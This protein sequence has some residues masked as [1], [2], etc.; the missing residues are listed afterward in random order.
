MSLPATDLATEFSRRLREIE[1]E[2][3]ELAA[4]IHAATYRLLEL[5]REFDEREGWG[6]PGMKSCAHWLNWKVGISLG[7]AREKVRVAH[8]LKDLPQIS[9][10]FRRGTVSFSKVRAMTRVATPENEGYL[11]QIADHGTASHVEKLVRQFRRVKR[12][13]AMEQE[14]ARH[15]LRELSWYVDD[16]GSYVF[17]ARLTPEQGER[18]AR[19][20]EAAVDEEFQEQKDVPAETSER[21]A[22]EQQSEP[23]AQRR[24]DALERMADAFFGKSSN[25]ESSIVTGGDRCTINLHTT[26]DTLAA[27]GDTAEAELESGASV[28]AETS[29]RLACDCGVVHWHEDDDG[30]AL[31]VGRK[32]RSIPPAIRRALQRRDQGCR[33][34]G[35]TAHKYVDAHHIHHWA[36]GGETKMNNL[37]LLCRHHHRLVHEGG[38]GVCMTA[39]GLKFTDSTGR[40]IAP[41]AETRFRGNVFALKLGNERSG[42]EIDAETTVPRWEGERM[43]DGMAVEGLLQLE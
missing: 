38:Y 34:P 30:S 16:D 19:A 15:E 39:G 21:P 37:V 22:T 33:F 12:I 42:L 23:V 11:M 8:A 3:T 5:V 7:A 6:G 18:V 31:N 25:A 2:I 10:A 35:C 4:H 20:I 24:A 28:S 14:N 40:T 27:D 43:D 1:S 41:V 13:E 17:R 9:S 36:D 29:R 32:T 26:P